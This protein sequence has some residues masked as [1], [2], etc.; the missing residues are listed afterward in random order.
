MNFT[1][2]FEPVRIGCNLN[3]LRTSTRIENYSSFINNNNSN[4]LNIDHINTES[5]NNESNDESNNESSDEEDDRLCSICQQNYNSTDILRII[6]HCSHYY[7]QHCLD[8]WLENNTKCPECQHDLRETRPLATSTPAPTTITNNNIPID[9]PDLINDTQNHITSNQSP[10]NILTF[11]LSQPRPTPSQQQPSNS[12]RNERL[13]NFFQDILND[14]PSERVID[15]EYFVHSPFY[16]QIPSQPR[17]PRQPSQPPRQ[18]Q[19]QTNQ[20]NIPLS[21]HSIFSNLLNT[22]STTPILTQQ[23]PRTNNNLNPFT[24]PFITTQQPRTN[25]NQNSTIN[26]NLRTQQPRTNNN[27]IPLTNPFITPQQPRTETGIIINNITDQYNYLT[28]LQ[29]QLE[30]ILNLRN[31]ELRN[32]RQPQQQP[33]PQQPQQPQQSQATQISRTNH[34]EDE[35]I[36]DEEDD[37]ISIDINFDREIQLLNKKVKILEKNEKINKIQLKKLNIINQNNNEKIKNFER[38]INNITTELKEL[39][40]NIN[41]NS[42]LELNITNLIEPLEQQPIKKKSHSMFKFWKK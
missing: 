2:F 15:V 14:N 28:R 7:H 1:N 22:S 6:N 21:E 42:N 4:S 23:Q 3:I 38:N 37:D 36:I 13:N 18:P 19:T 17:Q 16:R 33:Q 9:L 30:R 39:K 27:P 25:N 20:S 34:E 12:L 32:I 35:N 5:N 29:S 40:D 10:E 31:E 41:D 26:Q 11:L 8:Q 24:N